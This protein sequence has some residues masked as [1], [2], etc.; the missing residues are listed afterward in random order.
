MSANTNAANL[1]FKVVTDGDSDYVFE[2]KAL[3]N[4]L[5]ESALVVVPEGGMV[6]AWAVTKVNDKSIELSTHQEKRSHSNEPR[7]SIQR[8]LPKHH[9]L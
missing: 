2:D 4:M 1:A 8:A 5:F 9:D 6:G 3:L 7:P